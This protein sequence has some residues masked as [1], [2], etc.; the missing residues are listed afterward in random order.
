MKSAGADLRSAY[1]KKAAGSGSL[2]EGPRR[3]SELREGAQTLPF[4]DNILKK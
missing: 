2:I 3:S 4:S 1:N